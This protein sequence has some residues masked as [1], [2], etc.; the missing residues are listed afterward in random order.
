MKKL[1]K[2]EVHLEN[3]I[4]ADKNE[5]YGNEIKLFRTY[6]GLGQK[7]FAELIGVGNATLCSIENG[8]LDGSKIFKKIEMFKLFPD[9][10]IFYIMNVPSR[11]LKKH[12]ILNIITKFREIGVAN[13][14]ISKTEDICKKMMYSIR[15]ILDQ[16][17]NESKKHLYFNY[18]AGYISSLDYETWLQE[19]K[20]VKEKIKP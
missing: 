6:L 4:P 12:Q 14:N 8:K 15:H 16:E 20:R 13:T 7:D 17:E 10:A 3:D 18:F 9:A 11:V 19:T 5:G 2:K 1:A